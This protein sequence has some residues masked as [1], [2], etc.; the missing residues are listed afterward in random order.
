MRAFL[1]VACNF[2]WGLLEQMGLVPFIL[3]KRIKAG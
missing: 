1:S 2:W 3:I